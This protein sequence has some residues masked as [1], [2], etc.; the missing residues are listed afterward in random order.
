MIFNK[1]EVKHSIII[2]MRL[3]KCIYNIY[4]TK[5]IKNKIIQ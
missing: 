4:I 1:I 3:Y 5:Q 2:V